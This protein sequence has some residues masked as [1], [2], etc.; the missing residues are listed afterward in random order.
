LILIFSL[1]ISFYHKSMK[2]FQFIQYLSTVLIL[3]QINFYTSL[4]SQQKEGIR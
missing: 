2:Q 1:Q 3:R 4:Q